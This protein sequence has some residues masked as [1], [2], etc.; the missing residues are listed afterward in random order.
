MKL[1]NSW[2]GVTLQQFY[3]L[4]KFKGDD[5]LEFYITAISIL[6][7]VPI[8]EVNQ[9]KAKEFGDLIK[10]L[11]FLNTDIPKQPVKDKFRF[12]DNVY[13]VNLEPKEITAGQYIDISTFSKEEAGG[14]FHY[15]ISILTFDEYD[16]KE[17]LERAEKF[18]GLPITIAYPIAVFFCDHYDNLMSNIQQSL[19]DQMAKANNQAMTDL[20]RH[21]AG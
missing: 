14:K 4:Q 21:T 16:G 10:Q 19:I 13:K 8:Q 3:D 9:M 17:M 11:S 18:K 2:E 12:E 20:Q 15:F 5:E 6:G 1:P 7:N